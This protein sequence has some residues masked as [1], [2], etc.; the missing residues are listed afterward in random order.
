MT[1]PCLTVVFR[2]YCSLCHAMIAALEARA[3]RG[4]FD[5]KV[6]DVD[7]DEVML[8]KWDELVPVLLAGDVELCHYHLDG[9]ALDAHLAS[10][11]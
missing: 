2:D 7:K 3:D 9:A 5:I 11:G 1:K 10:I 8:A 6:V 4:C